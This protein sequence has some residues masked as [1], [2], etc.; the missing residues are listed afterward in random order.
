[1]EAEIVGAAV[2][3]RPYQYEGLF[4]LSRIINIEAEEEEKAKSFARA[5][6]G[7]L[8][9]IELNNDCAMMNLAVLY[10]RHH[11]PTELVI[12]YYLMAIEVG[13]CPISMYNLADFYKVKKDYVNMKKYF[14]MAI[15]VAEDTESMYYM[16]LYNHDI[17]NY[18]EMKKYFVMI[19]ETVYYHFEW[20][21]FKKFN[22]FLVLKAMQEAREE[23]VNYTLDRYGAEV[24]TWTEEDKQTTLEYHNETLVETID[25]FMKELY[26]QNPE[27]TIYK[28]KIALFTKLNHVE[29]CGICYETKLHVDL[30]CAHCVCV[31]CYAMVY[32]KPCPFCRMRFA[33][34]G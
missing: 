3:E 26:S 8:Q 24:A 14:D 29:E 7:Y 32:K 17:R 16:A 5:E 23:Q 12:K 1:M 13:N 22:P 6:K 18:A 11:K 2:E 15:E 21:E 4:A 31:D 9:A 10:E 34:F 27:L 19:I 25:D 28:N 33:T 30:N 20:S